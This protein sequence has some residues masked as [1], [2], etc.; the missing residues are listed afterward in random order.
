VLDAWRSAAPGAPGGTPPGGAYPPGCESPRGV[1]PPWEARGTEGHEPQPLSSARGARLGR[2]LGPLPIRQG[3][4]AQAR[5]RAAARR[6]PQAPA[7]GHDVRGRPVLG[8][9]AP[10]ARVAGRPPWQGGFP[11]PTASDPVIVPRRTG[12]GVQAFRGDAAPEPWGSDRGTPQ[13]N[14]GAARPQI[15]GAHPRR[16]LRYVVDRAPSAWAH[17]CQALR[18]GA[19]PHAPQRDPGPRRGAAD[20]A[21]GAAIERRGAALLAPP[22]AGAAA[23]RRGGRGR[24][25]RAA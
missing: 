15:G 8:A 5:R 6:R 22:G 19:L 2:D 16:A 13:L 17:D 25:P 9:A 23:R 24:A 12:A 21:A 18:R 3:A 20:T 14:A 11:P 4:V 1:G 10:R 7:L